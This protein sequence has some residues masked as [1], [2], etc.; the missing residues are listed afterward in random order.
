MK[1]AKFTQIFLVGLLALSV[2]NSGNVV[3]ASSN[4]ASNILVRLL[5]M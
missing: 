4:A 3:N 2:V 5:T 1:K